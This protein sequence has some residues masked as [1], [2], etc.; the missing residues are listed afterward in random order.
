MTKKTMTAEKVTN[1]FS[2]TRLPLSLATVNLLG[3]I[4]KRGVLASSVV[5]LACSRRKVLW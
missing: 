1:A 5:D 2:T 3:I 4:E